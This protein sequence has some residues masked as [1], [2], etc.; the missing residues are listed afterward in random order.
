LKLIE[1]KPIF[2]RAKSALA[3]FYISNK[4]IEM[5]IQLS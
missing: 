1:D 2:I 3:S 4:N 5:G